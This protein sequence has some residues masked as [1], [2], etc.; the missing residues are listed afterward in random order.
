MVNYI[1]VFFNIYMDRYI[2]E[3]KVRKKRNM[4]AKLWLNGVQHFLVL[5]LFV[6]DKVLLAES[7]MFSKM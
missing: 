2:K 6:D 4:D 7:K 5:S 1:T 3:M